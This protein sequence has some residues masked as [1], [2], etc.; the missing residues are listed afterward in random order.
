MKEF[1]ARVS[2]QLSFVCTSGD[3]MIPGCKYMLI[4]GKIRCR[5]M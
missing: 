1:A 4:M 3:Q 2:D 5:D